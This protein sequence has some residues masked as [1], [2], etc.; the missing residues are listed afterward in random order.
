MPNHVRYV[1]MI[2]ALFSLLL[3]GL[4]MWWTSPSPT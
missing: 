2:I 3:I 1:L 4:A